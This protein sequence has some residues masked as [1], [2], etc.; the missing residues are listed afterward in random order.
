MMVIPAID[1]MD[2]KVV[3]LVKGDP[4]NKTIYSDNPVEVAERWA[5][6]GADMLH[7]VDLD[8]ALQTGDNNRKMI[9]KIAASIQIPVQAAGGIRSVEIINE[10]L[11]NVNKIVLGT[12]AFQE[13]GLI[14]KMIKKKKERIVLAVDHRDGTVMINGWKEKTNLSIQNAIYDFR[15]LGISEFLLTSVEKDGTLSGPDFSSL[16]DASAFPGIKIIASGGVSG[17]E[18]ILRARTAGCSSII[19]GKA[20]YDRRIS[21]AHARALA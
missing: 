3:R 15:A 4:N 8:A 13:P 2:G 11:R 5:S 9:Y 17:L 16:R 7:I 6:E 1:L 21:V 19:L 18:D 10:M 20:L 14:E 12:I